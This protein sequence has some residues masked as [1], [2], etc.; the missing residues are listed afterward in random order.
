ML[1]NDSSLFKKMKEDQFLKTQLLKKITS[2]NKIKDLAMRKNA[3]EME[4]HE[5][6][7][8]QKYVQSQS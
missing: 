8:H 7:K 2:E 4:Q 1:E 6:Q 5:R 3:R